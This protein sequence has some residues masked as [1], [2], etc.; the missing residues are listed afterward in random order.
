VQEVKTV[1]KVN[2]KRNKI[3][4]FLIVYLVWLAYNDK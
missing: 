3:L 2:V 4:I 1:P